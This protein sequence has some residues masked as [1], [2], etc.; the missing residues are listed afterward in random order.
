MVNVLLYCSYSGSAV[1]YQK[2]VVDE[3]EKTVRSPRDGE[4][5]KL[6]SQIWTHGGAHAAAGF[7]DG[8]AYFLVK[9]M[10]YQ[11]ENKQRDEQGRKVFMNCA[12]T[13]SDRV[14]LQQLADGFIMCY[15]AAV[16]KLGDLLVMDESEIGYTIQDF[17][18]LH[19]LLSSCIAAGRQVRTSWVGMLNSAISFV[20]L[21]GDWNYFAAQNGVPASP[22]PRNMM[23]SRAYQRMLEESRT[24]FSSLT[25]EPDPPPPKPP[26]VTPDTLRKEQP[27]EMPPVP[28]TKAP[29][30][31]KKPSGEEPKAGPMKTVPKPPAQQQPGDGKALE[32]LEKRVTDKFRKELAK[33]KD[34]AKAS[35]KRLEERNSQIEQEVKR[36]GLWIKAALALAAAGVLL[37]LILHGWG[38]GR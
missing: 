29:S 34:G 18:G 20:A 11:N 15:Q 22:R 36:Q 3:S 12:F 2:A 38:G 24:E 31:E 26:V 5:P 30:T 17:D 16:R 1:G 14:E 27:G 28:E 13:G 8:A 6:V 35:Q 7:S 25:A 33:E 21:E 4:I 10:N 23:E 32:D 37:T 19:D 9:R